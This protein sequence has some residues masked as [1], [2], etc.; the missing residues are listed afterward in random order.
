MYYAMLYYSAPFCG[1]DTTELLVS[2]NPIVMTDTWADEIREDLFYE[3]GY[4]IHGWLEADPTE[5][6]EDEFMSD[7]ELWL[8]TLTEEQFTKYVA[9]GYNITYR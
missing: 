3:Y 9:E 5:E 4:L 8:D 1:T 6:E 2:K 7:C